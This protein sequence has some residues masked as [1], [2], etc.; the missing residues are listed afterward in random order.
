MKTIKISRDTLNTLLSEIIIK[1]VSRP[2]SLFQNSPDSNAEF[3]NADV[4]YLSERNVK[5]L[6]SKLNRVKNGEHSY[7]MIIK[8]DTVHPKFPC[9]DE[10]VVLAVESDDDTQNQP[11]K[12]VVI[13][14]D[15]CL[16]YT[17]RRA[18]DVHPRDLKE[19]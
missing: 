12:F 1:G 18:G 16:Y 6:L 13:G 2:I 17:E 11:A 9:S 14:V 10:V 19:Q 8:I 7:C 15:D 3:C 5:A 4:V